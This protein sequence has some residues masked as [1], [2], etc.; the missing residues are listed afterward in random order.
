MIGSL[1]KHDYK[2]IDSFHVS[3]NVILVPRIPQI[4]NYWVYVYTGEIKRRYLTR[5]SQ[6]M[7][8][9]LKNDGIC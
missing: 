7:C 3:F 2:T 4:G 1:F 6:L 9:L 8:Q 5:G